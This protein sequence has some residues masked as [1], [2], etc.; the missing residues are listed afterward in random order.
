MKR[1]VIAAVFTGL[2]FAL[3][4][5]ASAA[6]ADLLPPPDWA[7]LSPYRM[8][9]PISSPL[10][11]WCLNAPFGWRDSP[12]SGTLEFHSGADLSGKEGTPIHAAFS[13]QVTEAGF[14][15]SYG[16]YLILDHANGFTTL[17][18]HCSRLLVRMGD[19]VKKGQ[20][21]GKIGAT[22]AAT[23]PHLHFELRLNGVCLDPLPALEQR[24]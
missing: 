4:G 13:G 20:L 8:T 10:K 19:R 2:L 16:N 23:G 24:P 17:Y 7:D 6:E 5:S 22:G 18:A 15:E 21:I 1:A 14:H 3:S 12:L 9:V 11:E